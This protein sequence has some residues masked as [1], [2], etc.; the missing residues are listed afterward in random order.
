MCR[1][2]RGG[3]GK[4]RVAGAL[5]RSYPAPVVNVSPLSMVER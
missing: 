1:R 3:R 2:C 5:F 4:A